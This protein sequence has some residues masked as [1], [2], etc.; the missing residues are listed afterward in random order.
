MTKHYDR[1]Q[2][3]QAQPQSSED[4]MREQA[5]K[6][7]RTSSH[8]LKG[9]DDQEAK[10]ATREA[11][12]PPMDVYAR[13]DF[14]RAQNITQ[15]ARD[16]VGN[17][18]DAQD[19]ELSKQRGTLLDRHRENVRLEELHGD[20]RKILEKFAVGGELT[21]TKL[22]VVNDYLKRHP[23]QADDQK[24]VGEFIKLWQNGKLN[25]FKTKDGAITPESFAKQTEGRYIQDRRALEA[26]SKKFEGLRKLDDERDKLDNNAKTLEKAAD[27]IDKLFDQAKVHK[28]DGYYQIAAKLLKLDGQKH[29][30]KEVMALTRHLQELTKGD[31]G[32]L[33]PYLT[34]RQA[35]VTGE[36]FQKLMWRIEP[37]TH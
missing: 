33:P 2:H 30:H 24:K 28:G 15:E 13:G 26:L 12:L 21:P 25:D 9:N 14:Y 23:E 3:H 4:L 32:K 16:K 6:L 19:K 18:A 10:R 35:L 31:N 11:G 7:L 29:D 34:T 37:A 17:K 22:K 8:W 27:P 1:P 5:D 20:V 36:N